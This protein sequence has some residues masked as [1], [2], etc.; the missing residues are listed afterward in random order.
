MGALV[1]TLRGQRSAAHAYAMLLCE[2]D[3]SSDFLAALEEMR[4]LL[5]SIP[6]IVRAPATPT[7]AADRA[8]Y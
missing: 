8:G 4:L 6:E 5:A 3:D 7:M 2:G 1:S